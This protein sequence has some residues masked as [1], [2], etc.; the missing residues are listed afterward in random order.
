MRIKIDYRPYILKFRFEAGTSRGVMSE[1][2]TYFIRICN[3]DN[4]QQTGYGEVPFFEG[5][6]AESREE[7]EAAL[8][9]LGEIDDLSELSG[10]GFYSCIAF[11]VEM[12]LKDFDNFGS[13]IYFKSSF[14]EGLRSI[15][16]NGLVWMGNPDL[17]KSRV[18]EKLKE[19]F[20]CIKIK[21]GAINWEDELSLIKYVRDAGGADL[22]IRLDANGAFKEDGCLKKLEQLSKYGIHSIEQPI[23]QGNIAA[24]E[25]ICR[26]SPIPIALDEE[27]IGI[28]PGSQRAELLEYVIPHYL[29]LKP[30]LCYGFSGASDWIERAG[31]HGIEWWVTSALESNVGLD[32][33]S[34][35]TAFRLGCP[36]T[37]NMTERFQGLGTG[38]LYSNNFTSP[39]TLDGER[40]RFNGKSTAFRNELRHLFET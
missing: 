17:M 12:A 19:G 4:P 29:V 13:G 35:Y 15:P 7:T 27:L 16:I 1:K 11:G 39:L 9:R 5:L 24:L 21:I 30:A 3:I 10:S 2:L 38:N 28:P 22:I 37:D 6:S 32:A 26:E 14:T 33:I 8:K 25:K 34:Q 23:R 36:P 40:L 31:R 20:R 18:D